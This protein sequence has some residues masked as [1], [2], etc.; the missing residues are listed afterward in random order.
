MN[1]IADMGGMQGFGPVMRED[2]EPVF[3]AE[4]EKQTFA[5]NILSLAGG[6]FNI[7]ESRHSMESIEPSLYLATSYYEHWLLSLEDILVRKGVFSES[8]YQACLHA[9]ATTKD[10]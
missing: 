9:L 3:H 5:I 1:S 6:C 2:D 4:W 8:E 7:D 10:R